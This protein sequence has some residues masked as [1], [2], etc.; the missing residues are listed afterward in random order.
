MHSIEAMLRASAESRHNFR[1]HTILM[2]E[3]EAG[4]ICLQITLYLANKLYLIEL[5]CVPM[6]DW[7]ASAFVLCIAACGTTSLLA[8]N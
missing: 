7:Q 2:I 3:L 8:G 4:C 5:Q 6:L 1:N